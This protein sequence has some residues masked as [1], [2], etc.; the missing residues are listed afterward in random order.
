V[1]TALA[2]PEIACPLGVYFPYPESTSG[3]TS[4]AAF[5]GEGIEPL[6]AKHVFVDMNRNGVWDY[7][8]TPTQAWRRLGLLSKNEN[9]TREKYVACVQRA[10]EHLRTEG[11]FSEATVAFY[12]EQAKTVDLQPKTSASQR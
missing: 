7:R 11:F 9:L 10:A 1:E 4:F 3:T 5:T 12:L 2:F 6:D 8:E